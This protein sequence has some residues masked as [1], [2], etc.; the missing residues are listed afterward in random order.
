LELLARPAIAGRDNAPG[1]Q[2]AGDLIYLLGETSPDFSGSELQWLTRGEAVF[3]PKAAEK[4][5][6]VQDLVAAA[7]EPGLVASA[8]EVSAGGFAVAMAEC[9][10]H[11]DLLLGAGVFADVFTA[12]ESVTPT[13]F[14]FSEKHTRFIVSVSP[15]HKDSFEELAG[16]L[17]PLGSVTSDSTLN[18]ELNEENAISVSVKKL[19]DTWRTTA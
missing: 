7:K 3:A 8:C 2:S 18:I 16:G 11:G 4:L 9:L 1:F 6:A 12:G 14:L 15:K 19:H 17:K 10:I 13:A 5:K